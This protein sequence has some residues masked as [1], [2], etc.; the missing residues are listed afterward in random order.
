MRIPV[1]SELL[2]MLT[3]CRPMGSTTERAFINRYIACLP[4]AECDPFGNWHVRIGESRILWSSHTDTVHW[5]DGRQTIAFNELTGVAKLSRKSRKR[6]QCLGAD[7]TAGVWIMRQ[8][9]LRGV[10]GHYVFHYGEER[11]GHGSSNLAHYRKS[12]LRES[13]DYAIA[14]DRKADCSIITEQA[15]GRCASDLFALSLSEELVRVS[16][17]RLQADE[18]GVF[19]DT[20]SYAEIIPECSNLSIGFRDE[21]TRRET[22]D[23]FYALRLLD[24]M[25]AIDLSAF[26]V[27]RDPND[28]R[29]YDRYDRYSL[30]SD[31]G[32]PIDVVHEC[33]F[34]T[35]GMDCECATEDHGVFMSSALTQTKPATVIAID[36]ARAHRADNAVTE[37]DSTYLDPQF[38]EIQR[39]LHAQKGGL[40]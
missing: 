33:P 7:C 23:C 29:H 19:T 27:D 17:V 10:S 26:I 34:H 12:W 36:R 5:D 2:D 8:M 24:A 15:G 9:I 20:A 39:A 35:I 25:C 6:S 3:Y 18:W 1:L 28:W 16:D 4:G 21:H 32:Q 38:A 14:F 40:F 22:L 31:Y 37:C 13:F 11:G 30:S